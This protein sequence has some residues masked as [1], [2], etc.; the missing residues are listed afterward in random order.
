MTKSD[1]VITNV[2]AHTPDG[3]KQNWWVAAQGGLITSMGPSGSEPDAHTVVNGGGLILSPG[4]IDVH[5]HG[6]GGGGIVPGNSDATLAGIH[7]ALEYHASKGTT[8]LVISTV[9]MSPENTLQAAAD[10]HAAMESQAGLIG[11]HLEGPFLN[12][13]KAGAHDPESLRNPSAAEI[14]AIIHAAGA[15]G[16]QITMA[17]ELPGASEAIATLVSQGWR[18]AVGHTLA[19]AT[20]TTEAFSAGATGITHAFNAM[21]PISGRNPGPLGAAVAAPQVF[22]EV[23]ADGHH[24]DP[25][26]I[27]LLFH[28]FTNRLM[29]VSDAISTAGQPDGPAVLGNLEIDITNSVARTATGSLAGSTH[30]VSS[31]IKNVIESCSISPE[32]ALKAATSAPARYLGEQ[33]RWGSLGTGFVADFVLWNKDFTPARVWRDGQEIISQQS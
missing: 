1:L 24:V 8:R 4:L 23:I 33:D 7:A 18:V 16:V 13:E 11:I 17:P 25:D 10:V 9:S 12:A 32:Q 5:C 21:P 28:T 27:T 30:T 19:D 6:G 14:E 22:L 20:Q 2:D 3:V 15:T 31:G 29:L 26:A